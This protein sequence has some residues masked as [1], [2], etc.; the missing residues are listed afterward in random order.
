MFCTLL[1]LSM[2]DGAERES[3]LP[4]P[5]GLQPSDASIFSMYSALLSEDSPVRIP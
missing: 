3:V 5:E 4:E 1:L 2:R